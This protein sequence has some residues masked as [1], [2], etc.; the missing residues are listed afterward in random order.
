MSGATGTAAAASGGQALGRALGRAL[1]GR[2]AAASEGAASLAQ[3]APGKGPAA[4]PPPPPA[5]EFGSVALRPEPMQGAKD[6]C[7]VS[8]L[9]PPDFPP[10]A[11]EAR[12]RA[13]TRR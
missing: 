3:S 8:L 9:L 12:P 5:E 6:S 10:A 1:G 13:V 4:P 11:G 2:G 7:R